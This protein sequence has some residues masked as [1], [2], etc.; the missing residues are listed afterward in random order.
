MIGTHTDITDRKQAEEVARVREL[1][2]KL[3]HVQDA[4]RRRIAR[5][6]HDSAGQLVAALQMQ[7]TP[8]KS[9]AEKLNSE[10]AAGIGEVL[11][12]IQQLSQELRTVSYLLHPP[13]LDELGLPSALRWYIEGFAE[14][15][16]IEVDIEIPKD[17]GRLPADMETTLFRIVQE[18]L[19]NIH[20]HSG[21]T[22]AEIRIRRSA[23]EITLEVRD[24][25]KGMPAS[26]KNGSAP[27]LRSGV[28]IQGMQE[29][30]RQ[31]N[32]RFEIHSHS[33][34]TTVT[35][36]LPLTTPSA[37]FSLASLPLES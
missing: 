7:L 8:M 28:G 12:L 22:R 18:S 17:L 37:A 14:R 35:A 16:K 10:F 31:L 24:H 5:E 30:V 26:K 21:S 20:R 15:S 13:L 32:G 2:G 25:G 34:G 3:L 33:G 19:T 4:E 6:L 9:E 27:Q 11:D 36:R 1:T 23:H 29:R